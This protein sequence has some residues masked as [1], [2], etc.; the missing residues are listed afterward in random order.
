MV[1]K[2]QFLMPLAI[3]NVRCP[4]NE[5]LKRHDTAIRIEL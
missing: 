1:L 4:C 2:A 5:L 3:C